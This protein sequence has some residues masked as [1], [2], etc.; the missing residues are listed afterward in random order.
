MRISQWL[1]KAVPKL[2][3][4]FLTLFLVVNTV[5]PLAKAD[6]GGF[7]IRGTEYVA[8]AQQK[9]IIAWNGTDEVL[10]LSTDVRSSNESEVIEIMPLPSNPSISRGSI[11][12]FSNVT[13]VINR[14]LDLTVNKGLYPSLDPRQSSWHGSTSSPGI[15]VTFQELIG[16]HFL[17]VVRAEDS[18]D[19]MGWLNDFLETKGQG[20]KPPSELD[21]LAKAYIDDGIDFFCIDVINASQIEVTVQTMVYRFNTSKLYYPLRIS[22]LF[23]GS[24]TISLFTITTDSLSD[25]SVLDHKFSRKVEFKIKKE[26]L[27]ELDTNMTDLFSTDPDLSYFRYSGLQSTFVNDVLAEMESGFSPSVVGVATL[28]I[29]WVLAILFLFFPRKPNPILSVLQVSVAK[30]LQ[31]MA[32]LSGLLG[33]ILFSA[34]FVLP[35]GTKVIGQLY[36]P[37]NGPYAT[38]QFGPY[39]SLLYVFLVMAAIPCCS[40]LVV[41]GAGSRRTALAVIAIGACILLTV[42]VPSAFTLSTVGIGMF[43]TVTGSLFMMLAGVFSLRRLKLGPVFAIWMTTFRAHIISRLAVFIVTLIGVLLILFW[44]FG[45]LARPILGY[46]P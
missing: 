31:F 2:L 5:S 23:S 45:I 42:V 17:T 20:L 9:A 32:V 7:A 16:L 30:R 1:S 6:R 40:F 18:Y 12:S 36:L 39:M 28:N 3:L 34:G 43:V 41:I 11:D 4:V 27:E 13:N 29:G 14:Y 44:L 26:A 10:M 33:V 21:Q 22:S 25:N 46:L 15:Y 38:S 37:L 35:W 24:T 8:E 19:L